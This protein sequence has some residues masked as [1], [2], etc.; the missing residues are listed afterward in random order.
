MLIRR[1]CKS[2]FIHAVGLNLIRK[3]AFRKVTI[4][5][6][7]SEDIGWGSGSGIAFIQCARVSVN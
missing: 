4:S 6:F 1:H 2:R 5:L 7:Y 3:T